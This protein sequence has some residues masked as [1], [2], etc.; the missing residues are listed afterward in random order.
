MKILEN[1]MMKFLIFFYHK[2][3]DFLLRYLVKNERG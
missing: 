1:F 2:I 3:I